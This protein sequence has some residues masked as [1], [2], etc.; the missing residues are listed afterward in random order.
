M[1]EETAKKVV[2]EAEK[3]IGRLRQYLEETSL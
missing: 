1:D 3:F 2:M